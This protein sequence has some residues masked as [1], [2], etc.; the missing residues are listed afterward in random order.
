MVNLRE[1]TWDLREDLRDRFRFSQFIGLMSAVRFTRDYAR[2]YASLR[3]C[4]ISWR[5][6]RIDAKVRVAH[7][8]ARPSRP[9]AA[10]EVP[11]VV[12]ALR[13]AEAA[14]RQSPGGVGVDRRERRRPAKAVVEVGERRRV[15]APEIERRSAD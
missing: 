15:E 13:S 11:A 10:N 8:R 5:A 3:D 9:I 14:R 4:E 7:V 12:E 6:R 2:I 1:V